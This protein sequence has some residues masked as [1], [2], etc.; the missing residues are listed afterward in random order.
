MLG[1]NIKKYRKQK[2]YSQEVLAQE[3]N[4]V[5]QTISKWEKGY[6]VPDAV[7][8]EKLAE[9]FEVPVSDLLGNAETQAVQQ[10]DL[11][12]ISAQL[13][14]LNEQMARELARRKRIR[15]MI[16]IVCISLLLLCI[17][18]FVIIMIPRSIPRPSEYGDVSN[19]STHEVA[20]ELYTQKDIDSAFQS[21]EAYFQTEF[22]CCTLT[23]CF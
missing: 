6:S 20:S 2:G 22:E 11:A 16:G 17:I 8:L 4:V 14:I 12:Q 15:K 7:M 1:E 10:S 3:M 9:L 19:Y 5:R 23:E 18:L 21:V 13:S